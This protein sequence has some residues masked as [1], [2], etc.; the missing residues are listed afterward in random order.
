MTRSFMLAVSGFAL[1]SAACSPADE[2]A[3]DDVDGDET[4]V[5]ENAD[6]TVGEPGMT[7]TDAGPG[8]TSN[9][10]A[11]RQ[12]LIE[13]MENDAAAADDMAD[14][15]YADFGMDYAGLWGSEDQCARGLAWAFSA[16]TITTPEGEV[17]SLT[18]LEEGETNVILD[19][20][21]TLE[22]GSTED[23]QYTL[24]L[25]DDG[26]MLVS[27]A[28]DANVTRCVVVE[29]DLDTEGEDEAETETETE[30]GDMPQ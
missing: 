21:C 20:S 10:D 23:R 1:I 9:L 2:T 5:T 16:S 6:G 30:T 13:D 19:T 25:Q 17:C 28:A 11:M 24:A 4:I 14:G 3:M 22:D 12:D 29:D 18:G 27:G 7:D 8:G 26:T 15:V